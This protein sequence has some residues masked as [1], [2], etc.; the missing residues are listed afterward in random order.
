MFQFMQ[1]PSSGGSKLHTFTS[2]GIS[3]LIVMQ[4]LSVQNY[5]YLHPMVFLS[6]LLCNILVFKTT[7]IYMQWYFCPYC[8]AIS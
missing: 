3:V 4:Y 5:I 8:Y 1:K 2:N 6:L 7:Y